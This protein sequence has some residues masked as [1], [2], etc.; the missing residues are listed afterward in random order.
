MRKKKILLGITGSIAAYKTPYLLRMLLKNNFEVRCILTPAGEH[1]VTR[2]TLSQLSGNKVYQEMF[3]DKNSEKDDYHISLASWA[4]GIVIAPATADTISKI[5][6]GRCEDLLSA[7]VISL[8]GKPVILAPAMN[9]AMWRHP[10]TQSNMRR[11]ESD[12]GYRIIPPEKG[13]LACGTTG[14]GRLADLEK[15]LSVV[16]STFSKSK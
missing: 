11:L 8:W 16:K 12:F 2:E 13:E 4:D 10:A 15:I 9:D 6:H 5:A 3:L 7:T 14:E 1:F